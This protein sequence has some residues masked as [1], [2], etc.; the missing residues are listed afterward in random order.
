MTTIIKN[1]ILV[2]VCGLLLLGISSCSDNPATATPAQEH[3]EAFG[4][5]MYNSGA[6]IVRYEKGIVTGEINVA[7]GE[8]TPLLT[9]RFLDENGNS[10]PPDKIAD[11]AFSLKW[12]IANSAIANVE[13]HDDD[14]KWNFHIAGNKEGQT[15]IKVQ[16][17]HN[18][19]PDF[20]SKEIP[21]HVEKGI[22]VTTMKILVNGQE[23][24]ATTTTAT[25]SIA[26][27][28]GKA[29]AVEVQF[30]NENSQ[31]ISLEDHHT[32]ELEVADASLAAIQ[33]GS[34]KGLFTVTGVKTG[35]TTVQVHLEKNDEHGHNGEE[36]D[37]LY[38]SPT[39]PLLVQ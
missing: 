18:D 14:G 8:D 1:T 31:R 35:E 2:C 15:S 24:A 27:Q 6:E 39:L 17:F 5:V 26:V 16:L 21:I 3:V 10:I 34:T 33:E 37:T 20:T 23:V 38:T 9:V 36:H 4:L 28:N 30:Y 13:H 11:K 7:E 32:I 12:N 25:G 22:H 29:V 19:H